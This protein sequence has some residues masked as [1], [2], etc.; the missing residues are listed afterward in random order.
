MVIQF[1]KL[2]GTNLYDTLMEGH[3][4][5][6][7]VFR[8]IVQ[9]DITA[10]DVAEQYYHCKKIGVLVKEDSA[11]Y[12]NRWFC[13]NLKLKDTTKRIGKIF[14]YIQQ[15]YRTSQCDIYASWVRDGHSY[16]RHNDEMDVLILQVWNE[17]AYTVESPFG[18]KAHTAFTLSPGDALYIRNGTYHTPVILGERM[19][20]SFSW[21]PKKS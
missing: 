12:N 18:E 8:N 9:L 3:E 2:E 14:N 7:K 1:N 21:S 16:G 5:G 11:N 6:F 19:T 15:Q 17:M 10:L 13:P 4:A 20:M